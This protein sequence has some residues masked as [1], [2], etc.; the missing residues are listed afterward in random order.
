L[1]RSKKPTTLAIT[2]E[3]A[4]RIIAEFKRLGYLRIEHQ[5]AFIN[6]TKME[7]YIKL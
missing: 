5:N 7:H 3:T 4:S 2:T 6:K 1:I